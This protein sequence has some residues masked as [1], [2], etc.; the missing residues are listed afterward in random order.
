MLVCLRPVHEISLP[1]APY[2]L[3]PEYLVNSLLVL[4][5]DV[6]REGSREYVRLRNLVTVL[7]LTKIKFQV[8]ED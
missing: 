8:N 2:E 7:L 3:V 5:T 1:G 4:M 6:I